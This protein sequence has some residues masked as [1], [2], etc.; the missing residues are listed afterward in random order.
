M[1]VYLNKIET[2]EKEEEPMG[3]ETELDQD[4]HQT[5]EPSLH[6]SG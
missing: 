1:N 5:P 6:Q 3:Q 4:A 2:Q